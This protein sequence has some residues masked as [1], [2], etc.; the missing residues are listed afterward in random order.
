MHIPSHDAI[1]MARKF[2]SFIFIN[3]MCNV[4]IGAVNSD[5]V[6]VNVEGALVAAFL[7]SRSQLPRTWS[8]SM[9]GKSM[10]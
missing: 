7:E 6:L 8:V 3:C 1:D 9:L 5:L 4:G 2:S 10:T